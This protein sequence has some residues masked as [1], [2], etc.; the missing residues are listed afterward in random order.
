M[1]SQDNPQLTINGFTVNPY[2]YE[3]EVD[4]ETGCLVIVGKAVIGST[5]RE[6]FVELLD[7]R[8]FPV[9]RVG[10]DETPR[11]MRVGGGEM[12]WS[13]HDE[14]VKQYFVLIDKAADDNRERR[15][16]IEHDFG[17]GLLQKRM[18]D[19]IAV[20]T[21]K[22]EAALALLSDKGLLGGNELERLNEVSRDDQVRIREALARLRDIDA[23][24]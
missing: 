10:I 19:E 11:D 18:A 22:L 24:A 2:E 12:W 14:G 6:Q 8:Y 4:R 20:L 21:A 9:V 7:G 5:E 23:T 17:S 1:S 15:P 13:L 3:G 16:V